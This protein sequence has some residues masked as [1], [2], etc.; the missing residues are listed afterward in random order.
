M[1]GKAFLFTNKN[2][3]SRQLKAGAP[4]TLLGYGLTDGV[5]PRGHKDLILKRLEETGTPY[6][7]VPFPHSCHALAY[8]I[9]CQKAFLDSVAHYCELYLY[10]HILVQIL[11][12]GH[13][14]LFLDSAVV[15]E[16]VSGVRH[17]KV[18]EV[19]SILLQCRFQAEGSLE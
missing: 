16:T 3:L 6:E 15:L 18:S 7:Y 11:I 5:V 8:D 4:P 9:D 17:F 13:N 10:R 14:P 12:N 2:R 1:K 19:H